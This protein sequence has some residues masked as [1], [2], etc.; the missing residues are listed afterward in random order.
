[1]A[2]HIQDNP[3]IFSNVLKERTRLD[4]IVADREAQ[5]ERMKQKLRD[6]IKKNLEIEQ[7][8]K[9]KQEAEKYARRFT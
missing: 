3:T 5:N 8:M 9:V 7:Q 4:A 6:Q 1:M 2:A